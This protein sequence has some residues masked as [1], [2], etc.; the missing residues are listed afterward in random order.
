[1]P[2]WCINKVTRTINVVTKQIRL[3][4]FH[5]YFKIFIICLLSRSFDARIKVHVLLLEYFFCSN[6]SVCDCFRKL[7]PVSNISACA[8]MR[9][10]TVLIILEITNEH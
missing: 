4:I 2:R 1:M 7:S 8:F 10:D 9:G 5:F 3:Q 6:I